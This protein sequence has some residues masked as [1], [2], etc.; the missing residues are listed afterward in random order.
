MEKIWDP[1]SREIAGLRSAAI[2]AAPFVSVLGAASERN[3]PI[4]V[5]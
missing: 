1:I 2:E 3:A 5:W 4:P